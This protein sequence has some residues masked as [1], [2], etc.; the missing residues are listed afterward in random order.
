MRREDLADL[1]SFAI[2]AEEKSFTKAAARL[3]L[4]T[5]T[6]SHAMR[7]LEDRLNAKL[8]NRTTRSVAPTAAGARLLAR[9]QP[10]LGEIGDGL[11]DLVEEH[12]G[13]SG[14]VRVNT[15]RSAALLWIIPKL[16]LLRQRHPGIVLDVISDEGLVDI[17]AAGYDA[18]I[19]NGEQLAKDMIAVRISPDYH[20]AVVCTPSYLK[21][22]RAIKKPDDLLQHQCLRY[23]MSSS[24][25]LLRWEFQKGARRFEVTV[26]ATFITSDMNLLIDATLT[27]VGLSYVLREQA[28]T[29][30]ASGALVEVLPEWAV[31][32]DGSFLYFPSRHQVRPAMRAVIDVLRYDGQN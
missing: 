10:A 14:H 4:S 20:T 25:S 8:L 17:V 7:L 12:Q 15:H 2:I 23:R 6:L 30:L 9:L 31:A 5:S 19:R 29:H 18:G 22:S 1:M 11:Q 28:A 26:P 13:P 32:H 24:G 21:S 16:A 27:G 3:G